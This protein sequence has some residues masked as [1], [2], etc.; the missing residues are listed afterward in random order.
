M[1]QSCGCGLACHSGPEAASPPPSLT[2]HWRVGGMDCP[3]CARKVEQAVSR[4]DEVNGAKVLFASQRLSV[5]LAPGAAPNRVEEA[6]TRLG[7]TLESEGPANRQRQPLTPAGAAS[8]RRIWRD[9]AWLLGLILAGW[10]LGLLWPGRWD[11]WVFLPAVLWGGWP[12]A[13]KAGRLL[14]SGSPFTIESLMTLAIGGALLLGE[15]A[16][17]AVV[18]LL[19]QLGERMEAHAAHRARQGVRALQALVPERALLLRDGERRS[20]DVADL[21]PGDRIEVAP[22]GRLPLDAVLESPMASFD[23]SVLT[24][25]SLP[26]LRQ[27]GDTLAA[28]SLAVDSVVQLRVCSAPGHSSLDRLQQLIDEAEARRAPIERLID[29]FSRYYTPAMLAAAL[30]V[31]VIPPLLTDADWQTWSYRGLALLLIGCPCALVISTPAAV[32]AGLAAASRKGALVKGGAAMEQLGNIQIMAF[33][34]TGTLTRGRPELTG[35]A[36]VAGE[37][38]ANVLGLA[39]AVELGSYH[40]LGQAIVMAAQARNLVLPEAQAKRTEP[41][42]GV[43]GRVGDHHIRVLAPHRLPAGQ[44]PAALAG[45]LASDEHEGHS[46]VAVLR[47]DNV[48]GLLLLRDA[49]RPDARASLAELQAQG[50]R[51]LMLTGD[52]PAAAAAIAGQL[53]IDFRAGLLPQ[54]KVA[55]IAALNQQGL[56]AMVG[57]GINDAPAMKQSRMGIAMGTGTDVAREAADIALTHNRLSELPRLVALARATHGNI[58]QNIAI[59]LGLK[60]VFMITTLLGLTGLWLA[61]LADSGA[62]ALVTANALRILRQR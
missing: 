48:I 26:V 49:L 28:G 50:I 17:A 61:V 47:D 30:L 24:G 53:G 20:V 27:A 1:S 5:D 11:G 18:L 22:G 13:I 9:V 38:E 8:T 37:S 40:P 51:C 6:V 16:E 10:G 12:L 3:A 35:I 43:E 56:T 42:L 14:Q 60:G 31:V 58:R 2:H 15:T 21:Q 36:C 33:D 59:A 39:A 46:G 34:K 29:R 62:T 7:F 57:D 4:L 23:E 45:R 25:E 19:F 54:D 55:A 41:G 44:L 32:T 52:N